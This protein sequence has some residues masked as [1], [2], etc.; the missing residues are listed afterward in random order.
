MERARRELRVL[1]AS[2]SR[3]ARG[4]LRDA[5]RV[6]LSRGQDALG[7][8]LVPGGIY[9]ESLVPGRGGR[10]RGSVLPGAWAE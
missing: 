2:L 4:S 3:D 6:R 8:L 5:A 7:S 1:L 9:L 10:T